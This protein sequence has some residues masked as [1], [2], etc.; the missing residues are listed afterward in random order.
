M[1]AD[2]PGDRPSVSVPAGTD[3][4]YD[5]V[6]PDKTNQAVGLINVARKSSGS[7]G[8]ALAQPFWRSAQQ[9]SSSRLSEHMRA[10]RY[11]IPADHS[12]Q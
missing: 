12:R 11:W 8:V 9:S 5:G 4:F 10:V 2:L 1:V 6:P 7:M 3:S